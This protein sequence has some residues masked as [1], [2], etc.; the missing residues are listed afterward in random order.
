MAGRIF[1]YHGTKSKGKITVN[2]MPI[3]APVA[4]LWK[5]PGITPN[6]MG[7]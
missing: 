5:N 2:T 3:W 1:R 6:F 7:I 4:V